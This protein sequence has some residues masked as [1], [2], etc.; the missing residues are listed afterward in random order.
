MPP[1]RLRGAPVAPMLG[2]AKTERVLA[3]MTAAHQSLVLVTTHGMTR[4]LAAGSV[5]SAE[6]GSPLME[7]KSGDRVVSACPADE[8]IDLVIVADD[9]RALR[10]PVSGLSLRSSSGGAVGM[11][12]YAGVSAVGAGV[13]AAGLP[14]AGDAAV[15]ASADADAG[16]A[17][18]GTGAAGIVM[19]TTTGGLK[20]TLCSELP[21]RGGRGGR[22]ILVAKLARGEKVSTAAVIPDPSPD[23]RGDSH[24]ASGAGFCPR[25]RHRQR[26]G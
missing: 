15:G 21:P 22:G 3:L 6:Y 23:S 1:N 2:L 14:D 8:D 4:R 10:T 12:L 16:D 19:S 18:V 20:A 24:S 5:L 13:I 26:C 17:A 25:L 11:R 7:L 9:A